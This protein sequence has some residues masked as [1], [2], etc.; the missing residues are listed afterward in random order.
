MPLNKT[1]SWGTT[2]TARRR[3]CSPSVDVS[4]SSRN[5]HPS[6]LTA[7]LAAPLTPLYPPLPPLLP[8]GR[9]RG[10]AGGRGRGCLPLP[11]RPT[12]PTC[13]PASTVNDTPLSTRGRCGRY[14]ADSPRTSMRP[15]ARRPRPPAT[16]GSDNGGEGNDNDDDDDD[17]DDDTPSSAASAAAASSLVRGEY[18]A[19]ELP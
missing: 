2:A 8:H 6:P 5:T 10:G 16:T 3:Q 1:A 17:D 7:P 15:S 18:A 12:I 14:R 4:T 9:A 19:A 13:S 11:V